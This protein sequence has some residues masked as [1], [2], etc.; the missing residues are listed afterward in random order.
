VNRERRIR[1]ERVV[2]FSAGLG[3][4]GWFVVVAR[5]AEVLATLRTTAPWL[6]VIVLVEIG[7]IGVDVFAMSVLLGRAKGHVPVRM[8]LRG[9]VLAY[10]S[11]VLLPAG[12]AAGE[13]V[14]AAVLGPFVGIARAARACATLQAC[15]LIANAAISLA[16]ASVSRTA[17]GSSQVLA[18][19][20]C[21]NAFVCALLA[22]AIFAISG[23]ERLKQWVARRFSRLS[24]VRLLPSQDVSNVE[25]TAVGAA[26]ALCMAG[27]FLET[28]E[29]GV[30]VRGLGSPLAARGALTAQGIHL[31]GAAVGDFIPNH[32]GVTEGS[33][34]AFAGTLSLAGAPARAL[35]IA[36]TVH[37]VQL[38]LAVACLLLGTLTTDHPRFQEES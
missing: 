31:V 20:L 30:L 24:K 3:L 35:S 8:W 25:R 38:G 9:A 11:S 7:M 14:R 4:T 37:V 2:L 32:M 23:N 33:Y 34:L 10:A 12:R 28:V 18:L 36:L 27:R 17:S 26:A 5:T 29:Y 19:A 13:A 16:S 1:F 6:P 21:G 15:A 22:I